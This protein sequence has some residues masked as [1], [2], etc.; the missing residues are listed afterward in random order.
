MSSVRLVA[1]LEL[2][3]LALRAIALGLALALALVCVGLGRTARAANGFPIGPPQCFVASSAA[4]NVRLNVKTGGTCGCAASAPGCVAIVVDA[5]AADCAGLAADPGSGDIELFCQ[6]EDPGAAT[7]YKDLEGGD[8]AAHAGTHAE[9]A[10]DELLVEDLGTAGAAGTAPVSDGA[11]GLGATDVALQ[12]EVD[13]ESALEATAGF[14]ITASYTHASDCPGSVALQPGETCHEAD[15]E[16]TWGCPDGASGGSCDAAEGEHVLV[17]VNPRR[18]YVDDA[19]CSVNYTYELPPWDPPVA[20]CGLRTAIR[21]GHVV[22]VPDANDGETPTTCVG[23]S[24]P[25]TM[26]FGS[27]AVRCAYN[28]VLA[29]Y[30]PR[31]EYEACLADPD[32]DPQALAFLETIHPPDRATF[33]REL[34]FFGDDDLIDG[35]C[36]SPFCRGW[37]FFQVGTTVAYE[38][39]DQTH[40]HAAT[41]TVGTQANDGFSFCQPGAVRVRDVLA[42]D[43]TSGMH[44]G[45]FQAAIQFEDAANSRFFVGL[46]G[47]GC[48]QSFWTQST[49]GVDVIG[50]WMD[51]REMWAVARSNAAAD[52]DPNCANCTQKQIY[53]TGVGGIAYPAGRQVIFRVEVDHHYGARFYVDGAL[54]AW[55]PPG[56][57]NLNLTNATYTAWKGFQRL[58][59]AG[60]TVRVLGLKTGIYAP[61]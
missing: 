56:T 42:S 54:K 34:T 55:F 17:A 30:L 5:T 43:G 32:C 24:N 28:A 48:T 9:D 3:T 57:A 47:N 45:F 26:P 11:G 44:G 53:E 41:Y 39:A 15:D 18:E 33:V 2:V 8:A 49:M 22:Q 50:F 40:W 20:R 51:A 27:T 21:D 12:S 16:S 4:A 1:R 38:P 25:F 52:Y 46:S 37:S 36:A 23:P 6:R 10:A 60:S 61:Q 19:N 58:N 35:T 13:S 7:P 59:T 29:R 31:G 14:A